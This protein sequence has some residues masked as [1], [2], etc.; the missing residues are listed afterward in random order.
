MF[1]L[2]ACKLSDKLVF[3]LNVKINTN[4][5]Q[6]Q[7]FACML[8][9]VRHTLFYFALCLQISI[10]Y[11]RNPMKFNDSSL[12]AQ[13]IA[14]TRIQAQQKAIIIFLSMRRSV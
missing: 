13:R 10:I 4:P 3:E 14:R 11:A 7:P 2:S 9:N 6:G 5:E 8:C 1:K 12:R